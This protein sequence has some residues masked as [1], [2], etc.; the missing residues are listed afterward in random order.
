VWLDNNGGGNFTCVKS[1][2]ARNEG[3]PQG[4]AAPRGDLLRVVTAN[5]KPAFAKPGKVFVPRDAAKAGK[6]STCP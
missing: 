6:F 5:R 4:D 3:S 1:S 2:G